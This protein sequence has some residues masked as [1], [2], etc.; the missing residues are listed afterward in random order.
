MRGL[1]EGARAMALV[2]AAAYDMN[3][4]VPAACFF[5]QFF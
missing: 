3:S 1:T 4:S 5:F 2:G